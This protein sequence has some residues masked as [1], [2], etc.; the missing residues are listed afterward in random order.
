MKSALVLTVAVCC[1][2]GTVL[3]VEQTKLK[4]GTVTQTELKHVTGGI[5]VKD[6]QTDLVFDKAPLSDK[7][8]NFLVDQETRELNTLM[9]STVDSVMSRS[10]MGKVTLTV[11]ASNS[12]SS[13]SL[14]EAIGEEAEIDAE[15]RKRE[16]EEIQAARM[17]KNG[18]LTQ[19]QVD[20]IA[21]QAIFP[22][23]TTLKPTRLPSRFIGI[24]PAMKKN[25]TQPIVVIGADPYS[26][27][28]F[29]ANI[30]EIRRLGAGVIVTQVNNLTD[31]QAIQKYAADLQFQPM[32]AKEFL[33]LVG[34]STYPIIITNE[35]AIQ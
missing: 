29:K 1:I 30:G 26:L 14:T 10:P 32:D 11:L 28:W 9:K 6:D 24:E 21:M 16:M 2:P 17:M 35:G 8:I 4:L 31:F 19:E 3:A 7:R 15:R 5:N 22:V 12:E 34:V 33:Q 23:E 18:Q 20:R 13:V 25:I 27:S